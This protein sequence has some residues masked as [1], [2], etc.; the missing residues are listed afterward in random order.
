[1]TA[2]NPEAFLTTHWFV[3]QAFAAANPVY[4]LQLSGL[5]GVKDTSSLNRLFDYLSSPQFTPVIYGDDSRI[6]NMIDKMRL[7]ELVRLPKAAPVH[8]AFPVYSM[9]FNT[10][11]MVPMEIFST[12]EW[13]VS[14]AFG[15]FGFSDD[16]P[17]SANNALKTL[18]IRIENC[19]QTL[20]PDSILP[21]RWR[22]PLSLKMSAPVHFNAIGGQSLQVPLVVAV[23]RSLGQTLP[24]FESDMTLPFGNNPVFATGTLTT[25]N[26]FG[27]VEA[28]EKKLKGFIREYG[29]G[30]PAIMTSLQV[31]RLRSSST[32]SSLLDSVQ[33]YKADNL[34][35]LLSLEPLYSGLRN[36]CESPHPTEIDELL[37]SMRRM[38]RGIRFDD[39]KSMADWLIP[40]VESLVYQ[41]ELLCA[42]GLSLTHK[43]L[44]AEAVFFYEKAKKLL[45]RRPD[46]FGIREI[47]HL[48]SVQGVLA[49]DACD[50]NA[51]LPTLN[52]IRAP[53]ETA[54]LADRVKYWGT[55]CQLYRLGNQLDAAI[56][57]GQKAVECADQS[58]A[59]ESGRDRNYLIH[60]LLARARRQ[61]DTAVADLD[62]AQE[63]LT[64][65]ETQWAPRRGDGARKSHLGF[66]L[67]Y[68]A[69]IHRLQGRPFDPPE[70][71]PWAGTWGH[72]WFFTLL[73]CGRNRAH[74]QKL[75]RLFIDRL[76][77]ATM[78][79]A[80][81]YPD[82]LFAMFGSTYQVYRAVLNHGDPTDHLV[83]LKNWCS[84]MTDLGFPGWE[85]RLTPIL[86]RIQVTDQDA[87]EALC[88]AI[89]YH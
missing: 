35:E 77:E 37:S 54:S 58:L 1:M 8:H 46:L 2:I 65:S 45:N 83:I 40:G 9:E 16:R 18:L 86:N 11:F 30:M 34:S 29:A 19:W 71:P 56:E 49:V 10:G 81:K 27:P 59:S 89:P 43:G 17:S 32:G 20:A 60:A 63:L 79:T 7:L 5:E 38:K 21:L 80:R 75:R 12:E 26:R 82:S 47:I 78:P 61:A 22:S 33:V 25:D 14:D 51:A 53:I 69:E 4:C 73:A 57:A 39:V 67:H 88:D 70:H 42:A 52:T 36:L 3:L 66:C 44:F 50:I 31:E 74:D 24:T 15:T 72:P 62:K 28:L 23:L 85:N 48:A 76:V 41:F 84:H 64:A 68:R 6:R 87:V 13:S 55:L